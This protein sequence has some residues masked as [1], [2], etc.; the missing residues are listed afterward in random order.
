[1][2]TWLP[3]HRVPCALQRLPD[4]NTAVLLDDQVFYASPD[5][6]LARDCPRDVVFLAHYTEDCAPDNTAASRLLVFD[7]CLVDE[8]RLHPRERY[9]TLRGHLARFL[10]APL[11]TVQW[12]GFRYAARGILERRA[13]YPH[14][15]EGLLCLTPDCHRVVQPME[16]RLPHEFPPRK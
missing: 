8:G 15:I 7:V 11:G 13:E 16:L 6:A 9:N 4:G 10:P 1:M 5:A 12:V 14:E 3:R 2:T